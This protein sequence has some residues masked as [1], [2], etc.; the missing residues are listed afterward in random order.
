MR[1][2]AATAI[3]MLVAACGSP[4]PPA[5][6]PTAFVIASSPGS[7]PTLPTTAGSAAAGSASPAAGEFWTALRW[8]AP[9]LMAPTENIADAA[10]WGG[11]YVAVGSIQNAK[12]GGQ[13]AAW[14]S[15]DW[16]T[17]SRTLLDV[18][19]AGSSG[20]ERVVG[21]RSG[22]VAIGTSGALRCVP[23]EGEGQVCDPLPVGIWTSADGRHWRQAAAPAT[24]AG[25][26]ISGVASNGQLL[27][28]IGSTGWNQPGIWTSPD[29]A[30]W[31]RANLPAAT[32]AEAHLV[33]LTAERG[34]FIVTGQTGGAEPLCC[35]GGWGLSTPAAWF[36]LDG[37]TWQAAVVDR[38]APVPDGQIARVFAGGT[39][40]VAWGSPETSPGWASADGRRWSTLPGQAGVPEVPRASDGTRILGEGS[41]AGNRSGLWSSVDGRSWRPLA[42]AG[43]LDQAP[44]WSVPGAATWDSMFVFANGLG[45]V[46]Q[47][48]TDQQP[49]WFAQAVSGS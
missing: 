36:S 46:G 41:G 20:I 6:S 38:A 45:L 10:A 7:E 49:V 8:A 48:G 12:G 30:T 15:T 43:E 1:L 32:F 23:P 24:F 4:V 40:L 42:D 19:A 44:A 35:A 2:I 16:R 37:H 9:A 29:G 17:W 11:D 26:T 18:P 3:A 13:A 5:P 21:L 33:G 28:L 47:N 27:V 14:S 39:G 25:A 31:Q 34:G 22:L